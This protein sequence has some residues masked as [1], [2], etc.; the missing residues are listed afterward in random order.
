MREVERDRENEELRRDIVMTKTGR[1]GG[2]EQ[3]RE[4]T[5]LPSRREEWCAIMSVSRNGTTAAAADGGSCCGAVTPT[6]SVSHCGVVMTAMF[7]G[8]LTSATAALLGVPVNSIMLP[9]S[10]AEEEAAEARIL[11]IPTSPGDGL[12]PEPSANPCCGTNSDLRQV[13]RILPRVLAR[14]R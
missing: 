4:T 9:P 11:T 5:M 7:C 12:S 10:N 13:P 2:S 8:V 1:E 3:T 14:K 6:K